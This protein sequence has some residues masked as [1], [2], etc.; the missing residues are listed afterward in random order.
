M[1]ARVRVRVRVRVGVRLRLT[2]RVGL[3]QRDEGR[4]REVVG[5]AEGARR[6]H[7]VE[8]LLRS[9][10]HAA[11]HRRRARHV[12]QPRGDEGVSRGVAAHG[13]DQLPLVRVRVRVRVRIR[14]RVKPNL[15]LNL[16]PEPNP[17]P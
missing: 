2:L 5:A 15:N 4:V 11:L 14:V 17:N 6:A 7:D 3:E 12:E 10:L 1:G 13:G 8:G 16:N 9:P